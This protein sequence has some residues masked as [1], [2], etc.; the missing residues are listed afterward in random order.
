[1]LAIYFAAALAEERF[2]RGL[3]MRVATLHA[4]SVWG[5]VASAAKMCI[6]DSPKTGNAPTAHIRGGVGI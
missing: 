4:R 6:R 2:A 3:T 1:M 5:Y